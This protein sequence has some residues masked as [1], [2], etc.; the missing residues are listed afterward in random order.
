MGKPN[1]VRRSDGERGYNVL[2]AFLAFEEVNLV[3]IEFALPAASAKWPS[4]AVIAVAHS[5]LHHLL[6]L[7]DAGW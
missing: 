5:L 4:A 3:S 6:A 2:V 1:E 7:R